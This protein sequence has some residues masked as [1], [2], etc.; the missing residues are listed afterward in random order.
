M[1]LK[2]QQ[3]ISLRLGVKFDDNITP[4]NAAFLIE[5]IKNKI[6]NYIKDS[7][8][9]I[10][11]DTELN[12]NKMLDDIKEDIPSIRYFEYYGINNYES[13]E[14]QT[15]Y[16]PKESDDNMNNEYLCVQNII[17]EAN[18]NLS[19]NMV[20]FVPNINI[21]NLNTAL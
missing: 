4:D 16:H 13:S 12:I 20:T 15:I 2:P 10:S 21:V 18:S 5:T 3:A 8:S 1:V 6:I 11:V 9:D 7:Q 19:D 17:D 14:C